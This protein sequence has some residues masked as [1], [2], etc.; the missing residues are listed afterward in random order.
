MISLIFHS[1]FFKILRPF[2]QAMLL[3]V[4][5]SQSLHLDYTS[6]ALN[7]R[8]HLL[9]DTFPDGHGPSLFELPTYRAYLGPTDYIGM[10]PLHVGE[11]SVPVPGMRHRTE[12][13]AINAC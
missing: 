8:H 1:S 6:S 9:L 10:A 13:A 12:E 2:L 11:I 4:L 7:L 5:S 3:L